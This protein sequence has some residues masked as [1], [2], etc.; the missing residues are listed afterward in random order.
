MSLPCLLSLFNAQGWL[1]VAKTSVHHSGNYSCVASYSRPAWILVHIV[2]GHLLQLKLQKSTVLGSEETLFWFLQSPKP[3]TLCQ[4]WT[5]LSCEMESTMQQVSAFNRSSSM[6]S[7]WFSWS[8]QSIL[9]SW[10][11]LSASWLSIRSDCEGRVCDYS[12][13]TVK[14]LCFSSINARLWEILQDHHS[15]MSMSYSVRSADTGL[16]KKYMMAK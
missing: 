12:V 3:K 2:A 15:I 9:P 13:E 5:L 7:S 4:T 8:N 10:S 6:L 1:R 16:I 14:F 11:L